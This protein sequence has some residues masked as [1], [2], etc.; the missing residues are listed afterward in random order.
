MTK[1][2][3]VACYRSVKKVTRTI[4]W[5]KGKEVHKMSGLCM[6]MWE[7]GT[8][9]GRWGSFSKTMTSDRVNLVV[10]TK[11][12]DTPSPRNTWDESCVPTSLVKST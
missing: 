12:R 2:V 10:S 6:F 3:L 1:N 7:G 8:R 5:I 9:R 11:Q 4:G